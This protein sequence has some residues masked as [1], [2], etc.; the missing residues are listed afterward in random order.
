MLELWDF[1][2][3]H[4]EERSKSSLIN[5]GKITRWLSSEPLPCSSSS[6]C[7]PSSTPEFPASVHVMAPL[8]CVSHKNEATGALQAYFSSGSGRRALTQPCCR[9]VWGAFARRCLL[10]FQTA[11][12]KKKGKRPIFIS[13]GMLEVLLSFFGGGEGSG[14]RGEGG[15]AAGEAPQAG[16]LCC[17]A[18][19]QL[20]PFSSEQRPQRLGAL[21][22]SPLSP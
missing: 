7:T 21:C 14:V 6:C 16:A 13:S 19:L 17:R 22:F 3:L 18:Q 10:R 2:S 11:P 1:S 20:R 12:K 9:H 8:G 5:C 15:M 4:L